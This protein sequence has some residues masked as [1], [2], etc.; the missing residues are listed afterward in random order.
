MAK[1]FESG[2]ALPKVP[3]SV[4]G[5]IDPLPGTRT[6]HLQKEMGTLSVTGTVP[7]ILERSRDKTRQNEVDASA[8]QFLFAEMVAYAQT[9]VTGITEFEQLLST[10][11]MRVGNRLLILTVHRKETSANPKKP[12]RDT[13][14]LPTLIWVYTAFWKAIFGAQADSLERST[15]SERS[16]EYM[17]SMNHPLFSRGISIPKEMSQL[18]VEAFVA[19]IVEGALDALGFVR[20]PILTVQPA[21]VTAHS[22]PTATYPSRTTI[23]IKLDKSVMDREVAMGGP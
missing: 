1:S 15:E 20:V 21:R 18:S 17:I 16:D 7:D 9:R 12:K 4:G 5:S 10:M 22:M 23:L 13:R 8:L 6:F 19:G 14:L 11:G 2:K 3:S